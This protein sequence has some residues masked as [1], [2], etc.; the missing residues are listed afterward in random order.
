MRRRLDA[1]SAVTDVLSVLEMI[2]HAPNVN[3]GE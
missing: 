1:A 2:I 3:T